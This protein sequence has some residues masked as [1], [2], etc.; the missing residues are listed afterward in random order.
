M[1]RCKVCTNCCIRHSHPMDTQQT[2]HHHLLRQSSFHIISSRQGS[3]CLTTFRGTSP[4]PCLIPATLYGRDCN[5]RLCKVHISWCTHD[6]ADANTPPATFSDCSERLCMCS[7]MHTCCHVLRKSAMTATHQSPSR[8][9][10]Q[11]W[12]K[13]LIK[14][15]ASRPRNC[16]NQ[17][18]P[19]PCCSHPPPPPHSLLFKKSP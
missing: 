16:D 3:L 7:A 8:C 17:T 11:G 15:N 12:D 4:C 13:T 6:V 14:S 18:H 10:I 5:Q 2:D 19:Q 1:G 9:A